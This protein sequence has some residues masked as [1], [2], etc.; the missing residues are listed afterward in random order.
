MASAMIKAVCFDLDGVFFAEQ[1]F[2]RFKFQLAEYTDYDDVI[3]EVF[4]GSMMVAFKTNRITEEIYWKYVRQR[5]EITLA[6]EEI[7]KMLRESYLV[8]VDV[9]SYVR[10]IRAAGYMTCL[11]SNNFITR[12]RELEKEFG[13]LK[14]FDTKIYSYDIGVLKPNIKIFQALVKQCGIDASE[15]IYSDD[16]ETKLSGAKELGIQTFLFKDI[17]QFKHIL[18]SLGV[19]TEDGIISPSP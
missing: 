13:F 12:I 2:R 10:K 4:H 15:I 18:S 9:E 3:D 8:N 7:F 14:Y 5:L 11:C 19:S 6:N 1:S 16:S 17:I